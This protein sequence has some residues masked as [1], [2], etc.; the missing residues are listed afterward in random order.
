MKK[1]SLCRV[2]QMAPAKLLAQAGAVAVA[3]AEATGAGAGQCNPVGLLWT[4]HSPGPR[5]QH[6]TLSHVGS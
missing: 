6:G 4:F 1:Q 2:R 5:S 3:E